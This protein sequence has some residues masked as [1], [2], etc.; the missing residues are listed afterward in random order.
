VGLYAPLIGD[1][2]LGPLLDFYKCYR[3]TVRAKVESLLAADQALTA[4]AQAEARTRAGEYFRL[5]ETCA[6]RRRDG[7]A[8][9]VMG[10][11]GSGKSV[12]AGSL[13]SRLGAVLLSTD[14]LRR[15]MFDESGAAAPLDQGIYSPQSREVV[16]GELCCQLCAVLAGRHSVVI[17]GSFVEGGRRKRILDPIRASRRKLLVVECCAPDAVVRERQRVRASES[18]STSE[19]RWEVYRAQKQRYEAPDETAPEEHLRVDTSEPLAHQVALV[20]ARLQA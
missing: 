8:V 19:G 14:L 20:T 12:L 6:G 4:G 5:A 1:K 11:S 2:F 7:V 18:W 15:E 9:L 16:Y 10:A 3:A 17:D 13:A